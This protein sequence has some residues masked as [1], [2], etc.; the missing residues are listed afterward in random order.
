[1]ILFCHLVCVYVQKVCEDKFGGCKKSF[2]WLGQKVNENRSMSMATMPIDDL[3]G[4]VPI[5]TG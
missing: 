3:H 1:M 5:A 4:L 2:S